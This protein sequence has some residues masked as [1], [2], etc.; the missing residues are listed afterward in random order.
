MPKVWILTV[1]GSV[2]PAGLGDRKEKQGL[3]GYLAA[4]R[5]KINGAHATEQRGRPEEGA[6]S[7]WLQQHLDVPVLIKMVHF[8]SLANLILKTESQMTC[9]LDAQLPQPD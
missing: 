5:V 8:L 2:C 1:K 3:L 4:S 9:Q 6:L 7:L